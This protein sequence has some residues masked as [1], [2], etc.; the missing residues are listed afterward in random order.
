MRHG[1]DWAGRSDLEADRYRRDSSRSLSLD[2]VWAGYRWAW[3]AGR[4]LLDWTWAAGRELDTA[5]KGETQS[6]QSATRASPV[7]RRSVHEHD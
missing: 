1:V 2:V 7:W 4:G 3:A 5:R 6:S